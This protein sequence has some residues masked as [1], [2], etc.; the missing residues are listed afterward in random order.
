VALLLSLLVASLVANASPAISSPA[1]SAPRVD[2][3]RHDENTGTTRG[4]DKTED[5]ESDVEPIYRPPHRGAPRT[6]VGGGTRDIGSDQTPSITLLAPLTTGMTT[7]S[8]PSLYWQLSTAYRGLFEFVVIDR[9]SLAPEPLCRHRLEQ[10]FTP[11]YH[12]FD[13]AEIGCE[14]VEGRIYQWSVAIVR[15]ANR[16]SHDIVSLATVE[17][18]AQDTTTVSEHSQVHYLAEAGL[19]Y[20]AIELIAP[21]P[22]T[23]LRR[24]HL[25]ALLRQVGLA[26]SHPDG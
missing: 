13:L 17:R 8:S 18:V 26:D 5:G 12:A 15:D 20:D 2:V 25:R 21:P 9:D 11:G 14:L 6:R 24:A 7:Q 10:K 4:D 22:T 19:W 16:R 1:T 23:S 3:D